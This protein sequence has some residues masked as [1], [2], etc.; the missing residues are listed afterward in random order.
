M[1]KLQDLNTH[2]AQEVEKLQEDPTGVGRAVGPAAASAG[3]GA[4]EKQQHEYVGA[5]PGVSV[6]ASRT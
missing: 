3:P 1:V 2:L 6:P 4:T 5:A